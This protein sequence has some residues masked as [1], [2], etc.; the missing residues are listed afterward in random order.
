MTKLFTAALTVLEILLS[1]IGC[2]HEIRAEHEVY[3]IYLGI[4]APCR[5]V[6]TA[7]PVIAKPRTLWV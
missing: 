7:I 2:K 4:K 5:T 6:H 3:G 1:M